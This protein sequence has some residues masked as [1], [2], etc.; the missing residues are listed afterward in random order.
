[1]NR[2]RSPL[3]ETQQDI[4]HQHTEVLRS[5]GFVA[6]YK[7]ALEGYVEHSQMMATITDI[8]DPESISFHRQFAVESERVAQLNLPL[9]F[10]HED[11]PAVR[12]IAVGMIDTNDGLTVPLSF[13]NVGLFLIKSHDCLPEEHFTAGSV[14]AARHL[15]DRQEREGIIL[16]RVP[17][18][19]GKV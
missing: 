4:L 6:R 10:S 3:I 8:D 13:V 14:S 17:R 19:E 15:L 18:A 2:L 11:H 7:Q 12:E 5:I 9:I 1:M 16:E